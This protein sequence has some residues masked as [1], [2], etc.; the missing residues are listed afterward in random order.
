MKKC[1]SQQV[2]CK[3]AHSVCRIG[4]TTLLM[5]DTSPETAQKVFPQEN[6]RINK[7]FISIQIFILWRNQD[8]IIFREFDEE[9]ENEDA[10]ISL[11]LVGSEYDKTVL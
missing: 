11:R 1:L 6:K 4:P 7:S 5:H 10:E 9:N 2:T 8:K 3:R